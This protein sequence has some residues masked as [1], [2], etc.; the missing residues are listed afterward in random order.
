MRRAAPAEKAQ[1][2]VQQFYEQ[3]FLPFHNVS[4]STMQGYAYTAKNHV[5]PYLGHLRMSEVKRATFYNLLTKV[6]PEEEVAASVPIA[7][8]RVLSAM[9]Q[10]ALNE[11]Y[12]ADNPIRTIQLRQPPGEPILVADHEQWRRKQAEERQTEGSPARTKRWTRDGHDCLG[13]EVWNRFW[14]QARQAAGL[15]QGFTPYNARH[16][17]ISWAIDKGIDL[18]K[19]R[20][21]A[22]HGSLSITSR[23]AAILNEHDTT[24]ADTLEAIFDT[25]DR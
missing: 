13:H 11:E 7:V 3:R 6:L 8:R 23:Y 24:L 10:M 17:G 22:G 15:P 2:T 1:A 21:R 9:C 18:Q 19:V 20:Q 25:F 4:P 16:T 14:H 12:R 5:L